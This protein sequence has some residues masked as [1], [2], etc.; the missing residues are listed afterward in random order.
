MEETVQSEL[1]SYKGDEIKL[2]VLSASIDTPV[3]NSWIAAMEDELSKDFYA[4]KVSKELDK[5]MEMT[6]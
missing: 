6:I 4:G 5:N 1:K 2:G 3:Q